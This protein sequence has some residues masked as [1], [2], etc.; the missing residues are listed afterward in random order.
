MKFVTVGDPGNPTDTTGRGAVNYTYQMGEYEVSED[1]WHV[2]VDAN[3][4]DLLCNPG[5]YLG[6]DSRGE[7]HLERCGDVLQLAHFG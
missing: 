4:A 7:H 6:R 2:A 3:P 5:L 1:Q